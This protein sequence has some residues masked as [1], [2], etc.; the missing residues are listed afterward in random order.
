M[1]DHYLVFADLQA[2]RNS[3]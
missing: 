2:V 3:E 1:L